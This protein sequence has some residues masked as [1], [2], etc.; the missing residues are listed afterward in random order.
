VLD[1]RRRDRE[2]GAF[3][4]S[5]ADVGGRATGDARGPQDAT[6]GS[7]LANHGFIARLISGMVVE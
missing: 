4:M 1:R 7:L 5:Q 3:G 6:S 2:L